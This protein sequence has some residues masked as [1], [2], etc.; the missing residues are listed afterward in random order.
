MGSSAI[1]KIH[2]RR[3]EGIRACACCVPRRDLLT[4]FAAVATGALL[5]AAATRAQPPKKAAGRIDVHRHFVPPGYIVDKRRTWLND[6]S[7]I[8]Q[9]IEDMDK[10]GVAL[11]VTT[12]SVPGINHNDAA[13]VR[14]FSRL[15][16]EFCARLTVDHPGRFGNFAYLPFPDIDGTLKEIEYALDTLKADGVFLR[17]NYGRTFLGDAV[18]APVFEELNRRG[19]VLYTHPT[20]HPCCQR[21]VPGLRDADIEYGTN[22]TRAIAKMVFSGSSRKYPKMRVIW[23]H[24]GGT[25]PFLIRRFNKRVRESPEFQPI[26]PNGFQPEAAKFYYDIA[27]APERAPMAALK[28]IA[29]VSQLLFGTDWPHLTTEEH[30]T[31]LQSC[32]VF[33]E[34]ELTAIDRD[35]ALRLLPTLKPV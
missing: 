7:T 16:N 13:A 19:A 29:P 5:P 35:N 10:G 33:D 28:A 32:G 24:A 3:F 2:R 9:Q 25:M 23:S 14:K 15:A 4:G 18:F 1:R 22:T 8:P 30:V 21:L 6:R 11:A 27:Q 31:G 12:V 20:S 17:T 34:G 26:L